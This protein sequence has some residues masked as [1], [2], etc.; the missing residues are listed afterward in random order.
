MKKMFLF[1]TTLCLLSSCSNNENENIETSQLE[2]KWQ[3][4][5][6]LVDPGD[7][8]GTFRIIESNKTLDF[9]SDKTISTNESLCDPY[10][11]ELINVGVYSTDSRTITTN[12][13]DS[14]I[15]EIEFELKNGYLILNF[16]SNEGFSQKFQK[17][18]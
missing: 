15:A 10:S 14:N 16:I 11:T 1:L 17:L 9:K 5:E 18:D 2:G 6:Q 7:G 12:C 13:Q 8:S 4:I 3:L